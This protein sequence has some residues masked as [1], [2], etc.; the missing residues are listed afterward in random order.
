MQPANSFRP[1]NPFVIPLSLKSAENAQLLTTGYAHKTN[2]P[3]LHRSKIQP[4]PFC[5]TPHDLKSNNVYNWCSLHDL[6]FVILRL[7]MA[8]D[9]LTFEN[10]FQFSFQLYVH[11]EPSFWHF[12]IHWILDN[13]GIRIHFPL[14]YSMQILNK[15]ILSQSVGV[16]DYTSLKMSLV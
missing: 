15:N 2:S 16:F 6:R 4:T 11:K 14:V 3:K 8:L 7:T 10:W 9:I 1:P 5:N 12:L 13:S